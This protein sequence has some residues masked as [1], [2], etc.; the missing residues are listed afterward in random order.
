Y[1][2]AGADCIDVAAE[3]GVIAAAKD[4]IDAALRVA[5]GKIRSAFPIE[6]PWLMMSLN[7]GEDPHFRKAVFDAERCPSDCSRPCISVCPVDAITKT[8]VQTAHCYGC[9]RCLPVCPL[10]S[11]YPQNHQVGTQE[12]RELLPQVD[13]IEI[14]TQ[15]GRLT[16]FE[17]L[18]SALQPTQ[19]LHL[20]SV[21]CPDGP[22]LLTYLRSLSEVLQLPRYQTLIWQADGR[23]MS[24][25]LGKGTT[26]AAIQLA[27]KVLAANLP[28]F[29]QP[30]GGTNAHTVPK[31]SELGLLRCAH[32]SCDRAIAG[33]AYG[34]HARKLMASILEQRPAD[35][36]LEKAPELLQ[37]AVEKAKELLRPLKRPQGQGCLGYEVPCSPK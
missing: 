30:A 25:D 36:P 16:E 33:I 5:Q 22:G 19:S 13:A 32:N 26:R 8:G 9:G 2:L 7:D 34:S 20:I 4:G 31:L 27:N 35:Y 15:I 3:P 10:G 14:H 23:P 29:V 18:W 24:G 21:S 1:T 12:I 11:I 37:T 28:G 6:R 17:E